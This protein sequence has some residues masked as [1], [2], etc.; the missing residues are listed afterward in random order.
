M[1]TTLTSPALSTSSVG[2]AS[3]AATIAAALD[4]RA[5]NTLP[6]T[7]AAMRHYALLLATRIKINASGRPGPNV[8]T[9][10]YRRSW[11][12]QVRTAGGTVTALVHTDAPQANRLENGFVGRDSLGRLY[13]QAPLPHV[14]PAVEA[15]RP[16]LLAS[17]QKVI[18]GPGGGL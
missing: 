17:M 3:N 6:H 10:D 1:A 11:K 4:K 13:H 9:G 7:Q 14:G 16:V 5:R 8:V 18:A 12:W 15:T 2:A